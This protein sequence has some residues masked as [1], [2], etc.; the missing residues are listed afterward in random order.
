MLES[1]ILA[2]EHLCVGHH[3]FLFYK[4]KKWDLMFHF[5]F[6]KFKSMSSLASL[7]EQGQS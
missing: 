4:G 6:Q 1:Q 7:L 3:E 2:K 5:A